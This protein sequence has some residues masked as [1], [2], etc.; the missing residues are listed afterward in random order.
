MLFS[1]NTTVASISLFASVTSDVLVD[2]MTHL[3]LGG[4]KV[5]ISTDGRAVGEAV[6]LVLTE[7]INDTVGYAAL[8][9]ILDGRFVGKA[10]GCIDGY[11]DG[12]IDGRAFGCRD[13]CVVG[14]T[15]G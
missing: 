5:V 6:E 11:T 4:G 13:G 12:C 2:A 9:G 15:D 14:C 10:I 3:M 7:G 1:T 8:D